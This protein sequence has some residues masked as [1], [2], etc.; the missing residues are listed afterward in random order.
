MVT[1]QQWLDG[2]S[3]TEHIV[4]LNRMFN[5]S[6]TENQLLILYRMLLARFPMKLN[7][8]K[9]S[10]FTDNV[11]TVRSSIPIPYIKAFD[12]LHDFHEVMLN[13]ESFEKADKCRSI[14]F[15]HHRE[16]DYLAE[17]VMAEI[18]WSN[19]GWPG[20]SKD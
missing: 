6:N 18:N 20:L 11:E 10:Y 8:G 5:V 1:N 13:Y 9:D 17:F 19:I 7:Q 4:F 14:V 15:D 16:I 2:V 3:L 12:A